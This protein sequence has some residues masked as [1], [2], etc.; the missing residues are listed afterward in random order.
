MKCCLGANS[1]VAAMRGFLCSSVCAYNYVS[2][3]FHPPSSSFLM[4]EKQKMKELVLV[5]GNGPLVF[6]YS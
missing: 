6:S 2:V 3:L 5:L 4:N 1:L